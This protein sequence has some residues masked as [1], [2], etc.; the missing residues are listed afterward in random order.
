VVTDIVGT[1][2]PPLHDRLYSVLVLAFEHWAKPA[3]AISERLIRMN[4][5]P[6]AVKKVRLAVPDVFATMRAL[7]DVLKSPD[8]EQFVAS[9]QQE[10]PTLQSRLD[11]A[12]PL[13]WE[14]LSEM[15]EAGITI[16]SHTK[17]HALLTGEEND[18]V[19]EEVIQ[20][21]DS[22]QRHLGITPRHFAYPD[23]RF[24]VRTAKAVASV[25]QYGY[26]ICRHQL[27]AY[28]LLTIPRKMLWENSCKDS[29]G[30]FS[31][32]VMNCQVHG[33]FDWVLRCEQAHGGVIEEG[34]K[35]VH[36]A[37]RPSWH[38]GWD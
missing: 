22:L 17:S 37:S 33:L 21:R 11:E 1:E 5:P 31:S 7:F 15:S 2:T 29:S 14:M 24:N 35:A 25:Y 36:T 8:I 3:R 34:A 28:P 13:T 4:V 32:A 26:T 27:A 10:F 18:R 6:S 9:F 12:R 19:L 38:G 30:K 20:S 16:G 23:G